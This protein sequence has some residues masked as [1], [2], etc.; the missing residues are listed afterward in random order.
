VQYTTSRPDTFSAIKGIEVCHVTWLF[1]AQLL[2]MPRTS[3]S[4]R[5]CLGLHPATACEKKEK[6]DYI[7]AKWLCGEWNA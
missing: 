2:Q 5:L 4:M 6:G 1:G 7:M 3:T